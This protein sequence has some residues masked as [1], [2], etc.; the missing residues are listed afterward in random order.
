[1]DL[2]LEAFMEGDIEMQTEKMEKYF[3]REEK[4]T[5]VFLE[6]IL[7]KSIEFGNLD[8]VIFLLAKGVS[9][10]M[11]NPETGVMPLDYA[12]ELG[13]VNISDALAEADEEYDEEPK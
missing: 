1:M 4:R 7:R 13:D 5:T 8:L 11:P 9:P 2:I 3:E 10:R 12:I 6:L